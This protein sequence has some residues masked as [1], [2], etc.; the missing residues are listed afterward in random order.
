MSPL[1]TT[2][3]VLLWLGFLAGSF[4]TVRHTEVAGDKWSTIQWPLYALAVGV[5]LAGVALLRFSA[6][7]TS[8]HA[9]KLEADIQTLETC[10]K[11]LLAALQGMHQNQ[12]QTNVYDVR[13]QIDDRLMERIIA[14]VDARQSLVHSYG[15]QAYTQIMT[16]F[17]L[18]ERYLNRAWS[19]SAD[20]Y[21]DEVWSSLDR[22]QAK[23]E[24][25]DRCLLEWRSRAA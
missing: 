3:H 8:T 20:G 16:D 21:I 1:R 9:D 13:L 19:A 4:I 18:G 24:A 14:F 17:S 23:L 5:G 25:V 2:G 6:H 12:H 10:V 11:Q 22:A 15:L 7:R